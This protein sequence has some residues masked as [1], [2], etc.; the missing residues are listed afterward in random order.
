MGLEAAAAG[1]GLHDASQGQSLR[2]ALQPRDMHVSS[3]LFCGRNNRPTHVGDRP[4]SSTMDWS[5]VFLV[6]DA[7]DHGMEAGGEDVRRGL[8]VRASRSSAAVQP[9]EQVEASA[10]KMVE[11]SPGVGKSKLCWPSLLNRGGVATMYVGDMGSE[12]T[13]SSGWTSA[14]GSSSSSASSSSDLWPLI[15][16]HEMSHSSSGTSLGRRITMPR[17][18]AATASA[19]ITTAM[20]GSDPSTRRSGSTTVRSS[21][22][23]SSARLPRIIFES[24]ISA[25]RVRGERR[26]DGSGRRRPSRHSRTSRTSVGGTLL[27]EDG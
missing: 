18:C 8:G 16:S 5:T 25:L 22:R 23:M 20:S 9:G 19:M 13:G 26:V 7:T 17:R 27:S 14:R 12:R 15:D 24:S 21:D 2:F 11:C 1:W 10:G 4:N 6:R 3:E